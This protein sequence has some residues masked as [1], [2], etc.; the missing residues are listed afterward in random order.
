V[1]SSARDFPRLVVVGLIACSGLM[2]C[3]NLSWNTTDD[4]LRDVS[5]LFCAH[6]GC[7]CMLS[8][9]SHRF[10]L[11]CDDRLSEHLEMFWMYAFVLSALCG[12][13]VNY[14]CAE[15]MSSRS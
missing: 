10:E 4:T 3:S 15:F 8:R 7:V 9:V 14:S 1:L 13:V 2:S 5:I 11:F 6:E 12:V